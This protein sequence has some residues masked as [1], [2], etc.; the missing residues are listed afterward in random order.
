M[1]RGGDVMTCVCSGVGRAGRRRAVLER[2]HGAAHLHVPAAVAAHLLRGT[3]PPRSVYII[4]DTCM[5]KHE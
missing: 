4:L 2:V 3:V 1:C 5:S